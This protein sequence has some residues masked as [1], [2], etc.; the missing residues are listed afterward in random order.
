MAIIDVVLQ[1]NKTVLF[2]QNIWR[3]VCMGT[4]I[5]PEDLTTFPDA[6][7]DKAPE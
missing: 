1:I 4:K 6:S 5:F 3:I 2:V 7:N